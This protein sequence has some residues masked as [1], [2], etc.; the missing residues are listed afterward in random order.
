[1]RYQSHSNLCIA[2]SQQDSSCFLFSKLHHVYV[3]F[4]VSAI[5]YEKQTVK[6]HRHMHALM[7]RAWQILFCPGRGINYSSMLHAPYYPR[8]WTGSILKMW[9]SGPGES[10]DS[11]AY[12]MACSAY[13][14]CFNVWLNY[15][16]SIGRKK[17]SNQGSRV[18]TQHTATKTHE[19]V[20]EVA[21]NKNNGVIDRIWAPWDAKRSSIGIQ[22]MK[23]KSLRSLGR[24]TCHRDTH[25]T[26]IHCK[27]MEQWRKGL[28]C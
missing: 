19:G 3:H 17:Q 25:T 8:G 4:F 11:A 9:E 18:Y 10:C 15:M 28:A 5:K 2:S 21:I 26:M 1:M 6:L 22:Y 24:C 20:H 23:L 27:V 14:V 13:R 16:S 7:S 12:R